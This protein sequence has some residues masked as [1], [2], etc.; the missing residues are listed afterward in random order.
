ML[1]LLVLKVLQAC[2]LLGYAEGDQTMYVSATGEPRSTW[3]HRSSTNL[4]NLGDFQNEI[5]PTLLQ[6]QHAVAI[7]RT[8]GIARGNML[9]HDPLL[10]GEQVAESCPGVARRARGSSSGAKQSNQNSMT[11]KFVSTHVH[12]SLRVLA[13][14]NKQQQTVKQ[15]QELSTNF[16]N[17]CLLL[18]S[19]AAEIVQMLPA[20]VAQEVAPRRATN[21]PLASLAGEVLPRCRQHQT[22]PSRRAPAM[23]QKNTWLMSKA[24]GRH[25]DARPKHGCKRVADVFFHG[26]DIGKKSSSRKVLKVRRLQE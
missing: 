24:E 12:T 8:C 9:G 21:V 13:N 15:W 11:K 14:K 2:D 6:Q 18:R 20:A 25:G 17:M 5:Q 3:P 19:P 16:R 23:H 26:L 1:R 7:R 4:H 22:I 10:N